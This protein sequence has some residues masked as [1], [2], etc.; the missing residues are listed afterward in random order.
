MISM[1]PLGKL[2]PLEEALRLCDGAAVPTDQIETISI[3]ESADRVLAEEVFSEIDVPPFRRAAMDGYAV[4]AEDVSRAR[5]KYPVILKVVDQ[6]FAGGVPS[7]S[8][9]PNECSEIAT[10]GMLPEGSD[11]VVMVENTRREDTG[12]VAILEPVTDR[13]HV[14]E[15]G[16]DIKKGENIGHVG[17]YLTPGKVG[18]LAAIGR[19]A[20]S[21]FRRPVVVVMP[22]GDEIIRPGKPLGQGQI[23][24]VNTFTL[25]SSIRGFGGDVIIRPI[26]EDSLD[27]IKKAISSSS[28]ADIIIFSGG[29]SVGERDLI[30]DA[31]GESGEVIF[32]G[33]A[34]RP[35]KPT[36]LGKVGESLV[37]GMPGHPTSCLS[38]SYIFLRPMVRKIGRLPMQQEKTAKVRLSEDV[39]S[40]K[41]KVQV[42]TV[43]IEGDLAIPVFR[44]SSAITSMARADGYALIDENIQSIKKG[45]E[46]DVTLF[47]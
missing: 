43:K 12:S 30:I 4:R 47:I 19:E 16:D 40:P 13:R 22:T 46:I 20:L 10:G 27:S 41:G 6:I 32:H 3:E 14:I 15:A 11:A 42:L 17:D 31:V 33:V 44:E 24:D 1:R 5:V 37:L 45:E 25:V 28:D 36:I 21:V 23:Y 8:I 18:A 38:N 2:I 39:K 35:G 7:V 9:G 34:I 26:V 29:S